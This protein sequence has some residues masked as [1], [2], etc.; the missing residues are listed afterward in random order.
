[1]KIKVKLRIKITWLL[2]DICMYIFYHTNT[3]IHF[4]RQFGFL[5]F[6]KQE[7]KISGGGGG[8][9]LIA[10]YRSKIHRHIWSS[11]GGGGGGRDVAR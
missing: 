8:V 4:N 6:C 3:C 9:Y 1:M 10:V 2:C 11:G 5:K 7:E